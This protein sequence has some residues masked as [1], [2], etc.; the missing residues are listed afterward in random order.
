[1]KEI[2]YYLKI[3]GIPGES[4]AAKHKDEIE[5]LSWS[6]GEQQAGSAAGSGG[7][8]GKVDFSSLHA[9]AYT[10]IASPKLF[11]AC[12]N[13]QH[14]P[15][16]TLAVTQKKKGKRQDYLIIKLEDVQIVSY[17]MSAIE[18]SRPTDEFDLNFGKIEVEYSRIKADG[19]LEA[20]ETAG[21]D[22]KTNK[23]L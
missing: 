23:P 14:I 15:D 2:A 22:V 5:L 11:L 10:S 20:P 19:S 8:A 18:G 12:A 4:T 7:G 9:V 6:W 13:G 1:M 3:D 17:Q 21:W 16:V